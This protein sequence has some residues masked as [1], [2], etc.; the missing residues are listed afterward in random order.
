MEY[1]QFRRDLWLRDIF[2]EDG[3]DAFPA[4]PCA[5][6]DSGTV[7]LVPGSLLNWPDAKTRREWK[8]LDDESCVYHFKAELECVVCGESHH[9][10]GC[11]EIDFDVDPE[12]EEFFDEDLGHQIQTRKVLRL[13]PKNFFPAPPIVFLPD[14]EQDEE[15]YLLLR[16]SF[17]LFWIDLEACANKV[18]T[19]VEYLLDHE[20]LS[21]E[22]WPG[23]KLHQRI[24]KL[25]AD[26][27]DLFARFMAIKELGNVGSHEL[28]R[29]RVRDLVD[30]YQIVD[31]VIYEVFEF[32][33]LER[34]RE[35]KREQSSLLAVNL[36]SRLGKKKVKK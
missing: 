31:N 30:A 19:S 24:E 26:Q 4:Y 27:P 18:R 21:V 8:V 22:R 2:F 12:G 7:R 29:L 10:L 17:P 28:G 5:S 32:P 34:L 35:E 9:V 3:A 14:D 25:E 33:R 15:F 6:C 36:K 23:A 11:G 13:I 20:Q 16:Q 1:R